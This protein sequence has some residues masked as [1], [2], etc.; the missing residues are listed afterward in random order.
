MGYWNTDAYGFLKGLEENLKFVTKDKIA[1][2]IGC[3]GAGRAIIA[4]LSWKNIK[5]DKIYVY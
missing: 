5:I 4:A 3:G 2:I 1:L